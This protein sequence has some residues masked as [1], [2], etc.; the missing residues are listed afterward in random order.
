MR[1]GLSEDAA[2]TRVEV[3]RAARRFPSILDGLADGS[4]SLTGVRLL[5]RHLTPENHVAVLEQA[6]R[7]SKREIELLVVRLAPRPDVPSSV[8][9]LPV[10]RP[11]GRAEGPTREAPLPVRADPGAGAP[12]PAVPSPRITPP[13]VVAPLSPER[14]RMQL[15]VGKD[16]HDTLRRL[17]DLLRRE[18]PSGDP[19]MI[20]D[21]ALALLLRDVE[22]KKLAATSKPRAIT[23]SG[24]GAAGTRHVPAA[25][26]RAVWTRDGSR[27]TFVSATGHRCPERTFLEIHHIH[28][29]ALGGP[30]TLDNLR[31]RCRRHNAYE[32]ELDFGPKAHVG[33]QERAPGRRSG[34]T[35]EAATATPPT[36]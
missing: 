22:K 5:G 36:G 9:K 30:A 20:V 17:Q 2:Y 8:R 29:Y 19:A 34:T 33:R 4:L 7:R 32:A 18:I 13:A 14:Y 24:T 31:L 11:S 26:R 25:E 3:A 6:R 21:R 16:T 1:L 28:P 15:T 10:V 27:C 23:R 12:A 35:A